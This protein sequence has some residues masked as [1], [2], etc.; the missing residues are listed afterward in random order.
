MTPQSDHVLFIIETASVGLVA[1]VID[2]RRGDLLET[3]RC[4]AW[5]RI[6][7]IGRPK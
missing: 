4:R 2:G 6:L 5:L 7:E 3:L 1:H